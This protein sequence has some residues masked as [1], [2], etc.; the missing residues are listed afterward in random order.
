M[1]HRSLP[2]GLLACALAAAAACG[3]DQTTP[4]DDDAA[5]LRIVA[6]EDARPTGGAAIDSLISAT[7]DESELVRRAAFRALGRLEQPGLVGRIEPGLVDPSPAVRRAAAHAVAQAH[8][9]EDGAAPGAVDLLVSALAQEADPAVRGTLARSLGRLAGEGSVRAPVVDEVVQATR[10]AAG[11]APLPTLLGAALGLESIARAQPGAS[12]GPVAEARLEELMRYSADDDLSVDAARVRVL[13]VSALGTSGALT[14]AHIEQALTDTHPSVSATA[15]RYLGS[16]SDTQAAEV[17]VRATSG[18][19]VPAQMEALRFLTSLPRSASVCEPL[20]DQARAPASDAS[21]ARPL[22]VRLAAIDGLA[23]PCSG[24]AEQRAILSEVGADLP[25]AGRGWQAAAHALSALAA[26]DRPGASALLPAHVEHTNP[27]VRAWAARSAATLSDRGALQALADD[28]DPNVRTAALGALFALDGHLVDDRLVAAL[29][30]SDDPQLLMTAADLLGGTDRGEVAAA[31]ALDAFDRISAA[32]RETWRDPRVALLTLVDEVG[33]ADDVER[34]TPYLADYDPVVAGEVARIIGVHSGNAAT[35]AP[36]PL[37]RQPLPSP[38]EL[39]AMASATVVL[40]MQDLG[41][42]HIALHPYEAT[43]NS[44][45]FYRLAREGYFDGLTFHRWARNF[46]IQG[47]SPNANEYQGDGPF[48]RDEVGHTP[49]WRGT[50]GISTRGHDTGDGQIFV[51]LI[52]NVRLD[53]T[54]TI[55]GTVIRGMDVVDEV[56]EG[57]VIERAEVRASR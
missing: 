19:S 28:A 44:Y 1:T 4:A 51:N 21:E 14:L 25:A 49:H 24:A 17:A 30:S 57:S 3:P 45:R 53:H 23:A 42:I 29:T 40:H 16:L 37:P 43:T 8:H 46:V 33:S 18:P 47:G 27:F 5:Y 15:L 10:G 12:L 2:V 22:R 32:E 39:R 38:D 26:I 11:D 20:L 34:L 54:Y 31:A 36:N 41:E 7:E 35:P 50:V 13:A 9:T 52:D 48:T 56:L 55:I 6:L